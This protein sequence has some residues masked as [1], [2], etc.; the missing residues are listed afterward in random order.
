[1][2]HITKKKHIESILKKGILPDYRSGITSFKHKKHKLVFL[3]NDILLISL[4]QCGID[5]CKKY[6]LVALE[7]NT[8][9]LNIEPHKYS[10]YGTYTL[11][12]FEYV[13][14]NIK[15]ENII[16]IINLDYKDLISNI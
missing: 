3:T 16:K 5:Y 11:S 1:M 15:P 14:T 2:Y 4:T 9:N 7:I 13:T 8:I 10:S 12:D 6:E